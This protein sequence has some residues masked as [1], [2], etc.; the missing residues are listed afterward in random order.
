MKAG[1]GVDRVDNHRLKLQKNGIDEHI[2]TRYFMSTFCG[3]GP[4]PGCTF[5]KAASGNHRVTRRVKAG[6]KRSKAI[7]ADLLK[8][9]NT[10][11]NLGIC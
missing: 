7:G 1:P 8:K 11:R 2:A 6:K 5:A 10:W 9:G 3:H 4:V